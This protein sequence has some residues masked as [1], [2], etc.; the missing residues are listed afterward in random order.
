MA[1][2]RVGLLLSQ[3]DHMYCEGGWSPPMNK[4]FTGLTA[5]QAA[6]SPGP[7]QH[8]IWQLVNH[9]AFWKGL[10]ARRM[11]GL[12]LS[13][14]RIVNDSTFGPSGD[15]ADSHAWAAALREYL[16]AHQALR[17]A[18]AERE[19][20]DLDRPLPGERTPLGE[21]ISG[22]IAHDTYHLGQVLLIRKLQGSWPL[23]Q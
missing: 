20:G 11:N 21:V 9:V 7:G 5:A 12:P 16:E 6:S 19:D 4:A 14:E 2:E 1:K 3:M 13:G 8:T 18:L 17:A 10:V 23:S 22:L 15:P